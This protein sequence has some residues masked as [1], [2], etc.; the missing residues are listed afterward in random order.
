MHSLLL[1]AQPFRYLK[2]S[3]QQPYTTHP[4]TIYQT[5]KYINDNSL[6]ILARHISDVESGM[7]ASLSSQHMPK[8]YPNNPLSTN[9]SLSKNMI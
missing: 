6:H 1:T 5:Q 8:A 7:Y 9:R 2:V 4:R 3:L